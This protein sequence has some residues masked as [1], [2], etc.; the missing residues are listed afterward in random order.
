M[1]TGLFFGLLLAVLALL[2]AMVIKALQTHVEHMNWLT[3]KVIAQ[4]EACAHMVDLIE[5]SIAL[6]EQ[7]LEEEERQNELISMLGG[8]AAAAD[9]NN[10]GD[11][12]QWCVDEMDHVVCDDDVCTVHKPE[13]DIDVVVEELLE[14]PTEPAEPAPA[15]AAA[16]EKRARKRKPKKAAGGGGDPAAAAIEQDEEEE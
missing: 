15:P 10:D 12:G 2:A 13:D 9:R 16:P 8:S 7:E 3:R 6:G 14:P 5:D 1:D 11:C 4:T